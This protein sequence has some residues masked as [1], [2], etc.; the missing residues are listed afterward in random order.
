MLSATKRIGDFLV[1]RK[2]GEGGLCEVYEGRVAANP[3]SGERVAIKVV[4]PVFRET[5]GMEAHLIKEARI[6]QSI[7][8]PAIARVLDIVQVPDGPVCIIL[9][10]VEGTTLYEHL[11]KT[12][13]DLTEVITLF[14][15]IA[16]AMDHIH[17][18]GFVHR[19]LKPGNVMCS[20]SGALRIKVLDF[21]VSKA[22]DP[23]FTEIGSGTHDGDTILGTLPYMAPEQFLTPRGVDGK[24]D[25]YSF[26]IM[27]YQAT[28]HTL[29]FHCG[30][31]QSD[32]LG[33]YYTHHRSQPP[34]PLPSNLPRPLVTLIESLL[35]KDPSLRPTMRQVAD[36]L[37]TLS[38]ADT[39]RE[40]G[41]PRSRLPGPLTL[42]A[43]SSALLVGAAAVG[44]LILR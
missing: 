22:L 21:G 8:D 38:L 28:T 27:L 4:R 41:Q 31:S 15:Q 13:A 25:V 5:P 6:A 24:A 33:F 20:Q 3:D 37:A 43:V 19:N 39:A 29:P 16:V 36:R 42:A 23:D 44:W 9:E 40:P 30:G 1:V 12:R 18:R 26:G 14:Q 32:Q 7:D 34:P 35:A 11:E 10:F 17:Q 2:V